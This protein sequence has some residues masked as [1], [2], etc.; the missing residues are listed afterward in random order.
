LSRLSEYAIIRAFNGSLLTM[1]IRPLFVC[2]LL[3]AVNAAAQDVS[4]IA[5]TGAATYS[6]QETLAP[7]EIVGSANPSIPQPPIG[8]SA[9]GFVVGAEFRLTERLG[10]GAEFS[11]AA[12]FDGVQ[13]V[14]HS[15]NAQ[16]AIGYR[17]QLVTALVHFHPPMS[18]NV[19]LGLVAGPAFVFGDAAVRTASA[20]S[21]SFTNPGIVGPYGPE[22]SV[23]NESF[24][25]TAGI[26]LSFRVSRHLSAG[27]TFRAHFISRPY[28][29]SSIGSL[30]LASTV[31]RF[32][33]GF[34]AEF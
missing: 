30:Q 7:G 22:V 27:P 5:V 15:F 21:F 24:G 18:R 2:T 25:F 33:A 13:T 20:P 28:I 3:V 32:G 8:G 10:I 29:A 31:M 11:D 14:S 9:A 17:D 1:R 26:D 23:T 19:R 16:M 12:R 34:R 4:R 6:T